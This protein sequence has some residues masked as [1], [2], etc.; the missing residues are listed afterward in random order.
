[1]SKTA[2]LNGRQVFR[3]PS[4]VAIWWLWVLFAVGNLIDLVIQGRDHLSVVAAFSLLAVTGVVYVIAHRPRIVADADGLTI[5]NPVRVHHVGWAAIAGFDMTDLLRVRCE[6]PAEG[7]T[8]ETTVE[9]VLA[10]TT[11]EGVLAENGTVREKRAIYSWAARSSA[12]G[13]IAAEARAKRQVRR[14]RGTGSGLGG[15]GLGGFGVPPPDNAPPPAPLGLDAANV[16]VALTERVEKARA[17]APDA[18]AVPPL[19]TWHWPAVAAVVV[20]ALALLIAVL[21]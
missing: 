2:D 3:S 4:A 19:S 9:G 6:W 12:R 7:A 11:V 16:V 13:Q 17:A 5:V 10:E 15:F 14:G 1:M 20:P 21:T 18:R 8:A